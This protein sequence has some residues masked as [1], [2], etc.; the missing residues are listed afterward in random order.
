MSKFVVELESIKPGLLTL[1]HE[2][3]FHI[4]LSMAAAPPGGRSQVAITSEQFKALAYDIEAHASGKHGISVPDLII[5]VRDVETGEV[6]R[7]DFATAVSLLGYADDEAALLLQ[8]ESERKA[9]AATEAKQ[10][11]AQAGG[12]DVLLGAAGGGQDPFVRVTPL[13][14]S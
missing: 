9:K 3:D 10:K 5:H 2:K 4:H 13:T 1:M 11:A 14:E 7:V 6:E 8:T 12:A